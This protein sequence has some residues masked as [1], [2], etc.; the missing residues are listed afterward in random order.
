MYFSKFLMLAH[1]I[2]TFHDEERDFIPN[3]INDIAAF[4]YKKEDVPK[5]ELY[6]LVVNLRK[7]FKAD[8]TFLT[9]KYMQ[10]NSIPFPLPD[11]ADI[12]H[13]LGHKL[14][15]LSTS[16]SEEYKKNPNCTGVQAFITAKIDEL[17][18]RDNIEKGIS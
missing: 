15:L 7:L 17:L 10:M 1:S 12:S 11:A 8:S 6:E 3:I 18:D 14:S 5:T 2:I 4:G 16:F 13:L 9:S